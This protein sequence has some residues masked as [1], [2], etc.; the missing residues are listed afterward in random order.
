[1]FKQ[2]GK[3]NVENKEKGMHSD[4]DKEPRPPNTGGQKKF[5]PEVKTMNMVYM[6]HTPTGELEK[7]SLRTEDHTTFPSAGVQKQTY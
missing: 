4:D 6:T 1:M 2:A 7:H 5:P 3:L